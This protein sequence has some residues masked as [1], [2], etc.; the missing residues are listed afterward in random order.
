MRT[1]PVLSALLIGSCLLAACSSS[2]APKTSTQPSS[3]GTEIVIKNFS[4]SPNNLTVHPGSVVSV[5][6]KDQVTHTL[7]SDSGSFTTG[8]IPG[9]TTAHFTAPSKPGT[10]KYRCSIH[11]YMTGTIVVS[12]S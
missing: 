12:S 5:Q 10:Y 7:T 11:Q 2:S 9:G 4:F 1:M 8:N 6:N 3:A